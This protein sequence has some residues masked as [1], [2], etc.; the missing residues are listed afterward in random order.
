MR[1]TIPHHLLPPGLYLRDLTFADE[2][3]NIWPSDD[4]SVELVNL[5]KLRL[6]STLIHDATFF[7]VDY[8]NFT[9]VPEIQDYLAYGE[10]Q[11]LSTKELDEWSL[12]AE[13]KT[14]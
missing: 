13:P 4:D 8:Y 3:K 7:Q 10:S 11:V 9:V 6:V 14:M 5:E 12:K 1:A 2:N